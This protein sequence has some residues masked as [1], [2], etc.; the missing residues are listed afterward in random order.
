M[1]VHRFVSDG[2]RLAIVAASL[3]LLPFAIHAGDF[4]GYLGRAQ[5]WDALLL[6]LV[7]IALALALGIVAERGPATAVLSVSIAYAALAEWRFYRL[8]FSLDDAFR[9]SRVAIMATVLGVAAGIGA[10]LLVRARV[11]SM[12]PPGAPLR[13]R[14][15]GSLAGL[16]LAWTVLHDSPLAVAIRDSPNAG[17]APALVWFVVPVGLAFAVVLASLAGNRRTALASAVV[18]SQVVWWGM[19]LRPEGLTAYPE[20]DILGGIVTLFGISLVVASFVL[21]R[22][23]K[24][25]SAAPVD[26][27]APEP[28]GSSRAPRNRLAV[29]ALLLAWVPL[30]G[31]VLGHVA[32]RQ[33][34]RTG[35]RGRT[36]A[37]VGLAISYP[38]TLVFSSA[39]LIY[40]SIH[41]FLR[42]ATTF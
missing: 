12:P 25:T 39:L 6:F 26:S 21:M 5:V 35:A 11:P 32:L 17:N 13:G 42:T 34:S 16:V 1:N 7:P 31:I 18:F 29:A 20:E 23:M 24:A 22:P 38:W 15:I 28:T 37:I 36:S 9:E 2:H 30:V 27:S 10:S 19:M 41:E 40:W 33:V 8:D 4:A 3:M 14:A